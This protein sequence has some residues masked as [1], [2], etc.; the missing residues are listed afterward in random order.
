MRR[1]LPLLATFLIACSASTSGPTVAEMDRV[2]HAL[3]AESCVGDL[4]T[5]DRRYFY[6]RTINR[7]ARARA[8]FEQGRTPSM[9]IFDHSIVEVDLRQGGYEEF[10]FG[11]K[12]YG[13]L[14]DPPGWLAL[15]D[16]SYKLVLGT[17]NL[18]TGKLRLSACGENMSTP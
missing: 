10:G 9:W 14:E 16:R 1:L 3:V 8:E 15:D 4:E 18:T 2:E 11:R 5:W 7:S 6:G 12:S 17:F 13:D